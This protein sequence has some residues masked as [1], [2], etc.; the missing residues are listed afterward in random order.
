MANASSPRWNAMKSVT[1]TVLAVAVALGAV[2]PAAEAHSHT[3]K[4][5]PEFAKV[6]CGS[7]IKLTHQATGYKVRLRRHGSAFDCA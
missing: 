6:T 1:A 4:L 5:D 7:A 2:A 3:P